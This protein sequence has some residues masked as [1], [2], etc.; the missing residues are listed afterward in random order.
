MT[1]KEFQQSI[2]DKASKARAIENKDKPKFTNHVL[3]TGNPTSWG[4]G[5]DS[6]VYTRDENGRFLNDVVDLE[7]LINDL[8]EEISTISEHAYDVSFYFD[9]ISNTGGICLNIDY[10]CDIVPD[11][12]VDLINDFI[13]YSNISFSDTSKSALDE[14]PYNPFSHPDCKIE[15]EC[16][17]GCKP[18][19]GM[20]SEEQNLFATDC[21][22]YTVCPRRKWTNEQWVNNRN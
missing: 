2:I 3:I 7:T 16:P 17:W 13:F 8:Q 6:I 14:K 20:W 22:L 18:S 19:I 1:Y 21:L 11:K 12:D 10:D 4:S 15:C 5:I 9:A